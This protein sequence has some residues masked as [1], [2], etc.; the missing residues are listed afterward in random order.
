M[1][2]DWRGKFCGYGIINDDVKNV[3]FKSDSNILNSTI[4]EEDKI[5]NRG[6]KLMLGYTI[7]LGF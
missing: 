2:V 4:E 6:F 1:L 7:P 5:F 3:E